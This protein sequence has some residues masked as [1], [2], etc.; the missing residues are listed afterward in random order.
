MATATSSTYVLADVSTTISEQAATWRVRRRG[1]VFDVLTQV[2]DTALHS[3]LDVG[4]GS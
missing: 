2:N 3:Y 4:T 1:G